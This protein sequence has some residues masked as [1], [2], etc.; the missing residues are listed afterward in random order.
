MPVN[1]IANLAEKIGDF[2]RGR[3]GG[4]L[5][6]LLRETIARGQQRK[7]CHR[8]EQPPSKSLVA[9]LL[10]A[11]AVAHRASPAKVAC[12]SPRRVSAC[13]ESGPLLMARAASSS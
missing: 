1:L 10:D 7:H 9:H 8:R 11:T 6:R 2:A 4:C 12:S 13:A 3:C 5:G